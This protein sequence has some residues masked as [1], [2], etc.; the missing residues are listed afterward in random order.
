MKKQNKV[1]GFTLIE[2]I[3]VMAVFSLIMFGA[4][5]LLTPVGNIFQKSYKTETISAAAQNIGNYLEDSLRYADAVYITGDNIT[6][7][8]AAGKT[9]I[10]E[11]ELAKVITAAYDGKLY[12]V[13]DTGTVKYADGKIHVLE[14]DNTNG[15]RISHWS[16][17][18]VA[19]D[20]V[21]SNSSDM[22]PP[23]SA[24][25]TFSNEK[26]DGDVI[27]KAHYTDYNYNISLGIFRLDN[28]TTSTTYGQL[29]KDTNY[30]GTFANTSLQTFNQSNFGLTITA[31]PLNKDGSSSRTGAAGSY[32]YNPA[33]LYTASVGFVNLKTSAGWYKYNWIDDGSG[34]KRLPTEA[35][36]NRATDKASM[37]KFVAAGTAK[38]YGNA[39]TMDNGDGSMSYAKEIG[40]FYI[41]YT[42]PGGNVI[43]S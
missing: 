10:K 33:Y 16:Y 3:V 21:G 19:G 36:F 38:Y 35:E 25:P 8:N 40:K 27:N 23:P 2:L 15:G 22:T 11:A 24:T 17:D 43:K 41:L 9:I 39:I 1:K 5:Q 14:I 28:D 20:T 12:Q 30:Y 18:Y 34:K 32:V 37:A 6:T 31:Y 4:L 13:N 26:I 29:I 7:T 42:Y